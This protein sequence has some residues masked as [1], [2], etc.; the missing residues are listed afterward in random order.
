[1]FF[2]V[3]NFK[4]LQPIMEIENSYFYSRQENLTLRFLQ[5]FVNFSLSAVTNAYICAFKCR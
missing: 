4:L 2:I 5:T 1:M 3:F